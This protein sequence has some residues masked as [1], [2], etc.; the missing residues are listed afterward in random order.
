MPVFL[1][2]YLPFSIYY[3]NKL[4]TKQESAPVRIFNKVING[5]RRLTTKI[6]RGFAAIA[7]ESSGTDS[8]D[9]QGVTTKASM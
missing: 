7:R 9:K 6:V 1:T 4:E 2:F 8:V 5:V 3:I